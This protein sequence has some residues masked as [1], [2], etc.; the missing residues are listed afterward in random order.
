[1]VRVK[2]HYYLIKSGV[3]APPLGLERFVSFG[4]AKA[5]QAPAE[6]AGEALCYPLNE[7]RPTE[8]RA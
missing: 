5:A 3:K 7:L 4:R 1:M 2:C 6:G 8:A